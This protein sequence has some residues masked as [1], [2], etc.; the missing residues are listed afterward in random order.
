MTQAAERPPAVTWRI[1]LSDLDF[2]PEEEA[3]ALRV[4]RSKWLTLG[5]E[6]QAFEEEF[7]AEIGVKHAVAVANGTA[8]LHLSLL[9]LG[10]G[11]G[12]EVAQPAVNFVAAANM[13]VMTGARP[14]FCDI[15]SLEDPTLDPEGLARSLTPATKAVVVMHFGGA[16]CR[17][18]EIGDLCRD[19][20][21]ALI[22]D[23]CHGVGGTFRGKKMGALGDIAAF[24]FFSNKNLATGEGGMVTTDRDDLAAKVRLLRSH[25]MTSLTW[26]R[27]RGRTGSYGVVEHGLNCRLDELRSAIGRAQLR[28][29]PANNARRR[30]LAR[31][32][33]R[34]FDEEFAP[35]ITRGW[36]VPPLGVEGD[37]AAHHLMV[38]LAPDQAE[39]D[40]A[41]AHLR[42]RG[43]QTSIHYPFIPDFAAFAQE[44]P[45][46]RERLKR[47]ATF[48]DRVL[49]LPMHPLLTEGDVREVVAALHDF[50]AATRPLFSS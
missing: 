35:L 24:S 16:A 17:M 37:E 6:T 31:E 39:R 27:H 41:A 32:Y 42:S 28:K 33:H 2:G 26:D 36:I 7:A 29:L 11:R 18:D 10:V 15:G 38:A 13:T 21:L 20:G 49:T 44:H 19:R 50:G 34:L 23:A 14:A 43:I 48:C 5:P 4:L 8:A 12:D 46:L 25:G 47:S 40:A 9:A 30:A 3:A 45:G 22:E 1:T